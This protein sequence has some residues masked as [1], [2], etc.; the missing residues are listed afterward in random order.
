MQVNSWTEWGKLKTVVVGVA[1]F[2]CFQPEEPGFK[3]K[4]NNTLIAD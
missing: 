1:D 4:I 3:G 2:G